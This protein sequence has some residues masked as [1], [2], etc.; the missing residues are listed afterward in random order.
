MEAANLSYA[1][2]T[3]MPQFT[4]LIHTEHEPN[5]FSILLMNTM[6]SPSA[7][8]YTQVYLLELFSL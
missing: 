1:L 7:K 8:K 3:S 4:I 2:Q 5:P 6:P